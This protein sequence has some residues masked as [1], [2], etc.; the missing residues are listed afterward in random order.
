MSWVTEAA[1]LLGVH[2]GRTTGGWSN[3]R[4]PF[5]NDHSNHLG[6]NLNSGIGSCWRCGTHSMVQVFAELGTASFREVIDVIEKLRPS[7]LG[8][9]EKENERDVKPLHL[10]K[11]LI[12]LQKLHRNYL[13]GRGY[14]PDALVR[15]WNLQAF[16]HL[17]RHKFGIYIPITWNGKV[18]AFQSRLAMEGKSR[19]YISSSPDIEGGMPIKNCIY[20]IDH[21]PDDMAVVVE[22]PAD[23]WRLGYG[24][25]CTC[26]VEVSSHQV[27]MLSKLERRYLLFDNEEIAQRR[28]YE[29]AELLSPFPGQTILIPPNQFGVKDTGSM[30]D[31]VAQGIMKELGFRFV[32]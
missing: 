31:D 32:E 5:C 26:G 11:N 15:N 25:I 19:R 23:V 20:G 22:G 3:V 4:C 16:N 7:R 17:G 24:S 30:T 10:P 8:I 18:T 29:V 13:K 2:L 6:I 21:I 14:D 27:H 1:D 9:R 28:A 12:P